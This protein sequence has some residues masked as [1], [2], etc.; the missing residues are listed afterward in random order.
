LAGYRSF[1]KAVTEQTI[2]DT[3]RRAAAKRVPATA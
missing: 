2:D 3:R 1:E